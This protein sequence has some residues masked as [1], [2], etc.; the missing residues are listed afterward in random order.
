MIDGKTHQTAVV[1]IPPLEY[2][3]PIQNIRRRYDRHFKRWMPHITLLYPFRPEAMLAEA[4]AALAACCAGVEPFDLELRPVRHFEHTRRSYTLWLEPAPAEPI[5]RLQ[6]ALLACAPDCN[7]VNLHATGFLPH[8][9]VGQARAEGELQDR[10]ERIRTH[11]PTIRFRAAEV[12][13]LCRGSG[14]DDAFR[15]D[16]LLPL[17][18]GR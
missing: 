12:A 3:E 5:V 16:R 7:D 11:C 2:W 8:L 15:V 1:L 18:G 13:I 9:S 14:R 17:G 4:A 6:A 10:L